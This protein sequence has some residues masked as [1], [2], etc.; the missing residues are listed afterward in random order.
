MMALK[1]FVPGTC[2]TPCSSTYN[3]RSACSRGVPL[4]PVRTVLVLPLTFSAS[5]SVNLFISSGV[6]PSIVTWTRSIYMP[7]VLF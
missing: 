5:A 2:R 6:V 4:L 7:P 3:F 1:M